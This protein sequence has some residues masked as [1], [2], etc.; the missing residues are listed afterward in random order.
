[1]ADLLGVEGYDNI[2]PIHPMGGRDNKRDIRCWQAGIKF[3]CACYFPP[4]A[5]HLKFKDVK[6]KFKA[7]IK[8][9]TNDGAQGYV[10]ATNVPLTDGQRDD[11]MKWGLKKCSHVVLYEIERIRV[12]LDKPIACA[13][14]HR[15]L[16]IEITAEAQ[17]ALTAQMHLDMKK[18]FADLRSFLAA[19]QNPA[20]ATPSA[21]TQ[22]TPTASTSAAPPVPVPAATSPG[23]SVP[24][25]SSTSS[26]G[27][28]L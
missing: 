19:T 3:V 5:A 10:F 16:G 15:Y 6:K 22:A 12:L 1:M 9:V 28:K 27:G 20:G 24:G 17:I 13:L 21:F 18:E 4:T 23:P 2:Q 11:L 7:D 26:G 8:G 14:R 25:T